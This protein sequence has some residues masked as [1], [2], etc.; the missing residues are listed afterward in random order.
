MISGMKSG[1]SYVKG[2]GTAFAGINEV[3]KQGRNI[4]LKSK[5]LAKTN[6]WLS[7]S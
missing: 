5:F 2:S 7:V 3:N 1:M 4:E 6:T